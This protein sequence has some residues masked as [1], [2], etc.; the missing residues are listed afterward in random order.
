MFIL[1][2]FPAFSALLHPGIF[3]S[4]DLEG[5]IIRLVDFRR[6]LADGHFPVRWSKRLNWGLGY[7]YFNF[8]Y[9]LVYY[10]ASGLVL[11]GLDYGNAFKLIFLLTFPLGGYF[12]YLWLRTH[13]SR[14]PAFSGG[15]FYVFV[16][17]HFINVYVRGNVG[18]SAALMLVPLVL[19]LSRR[20]LPFLNNMLGKST[21]G[22]VLGGTIGNLIDRLFLGY[23]IDFLDFRI[24][25]VFNIADSA[26]TVGA[27][28]LGYTILVKKDN[29]C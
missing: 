21:L 7:P 9:P 23:V 8:N 19:F 26:I 10:F 17:Y 15:L 6:A 28:L 13:F 27:I 12:A 14:T 3:T 29:K 16:P 1:L 2:T 5:H 24:W 18:E 11:A 4:H 25:P 20:Y 22:L